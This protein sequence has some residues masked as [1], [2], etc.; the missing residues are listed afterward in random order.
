MTTPD[1]TREAKL[2]EDVT[3]LREASKAQEIT[4]RV[5]R[6]KVDLLVRRIL[7]RRIFGKSGN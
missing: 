7:V 5:L 4:I 6:D 2:T 1:T 3:A